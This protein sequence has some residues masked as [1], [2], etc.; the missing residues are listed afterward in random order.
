MEKRE[1]SRILKCHYCGKLYSSAET[2][3]ECPACSNIKG[4]I[5]APWRRF[6]LDQG[7]KFF[8]WPGSR[9]AHHA[10]EGGLWSHTQ[11]VLSI[12]LV[13]CARYGAN[14]DVFRLASLFHDTG[15]MLECDEDRNTTP[16]GALKGHVVS[17]V[18]IFRYY[19]HLTFGGFG[20]FALQV[21]HCILASHGK[22]EWGSPVPPKT[23]EATILHMTDNASA[24]TAI[25]FEA[26]NKI[27]GPGAGEYSVLLNCKPYKF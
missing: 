7:A 6:L 23:L 21:E 20:S 3:R 4:G 25:M 15:K 8:D 1:R 17:S 9:K 18:E 11:E 14:K 12:G 5:M 27:I 19:W 24:K 10:F 13:F 22:G 16:A 2:L 26:Q